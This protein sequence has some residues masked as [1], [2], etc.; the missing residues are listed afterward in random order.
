MNTEAGCT[1]CRIDALY[2]DR[3]VDREI[4]SMAYQVDENDSRQKRAQDR[5]ERL[6]K[7][8]SEE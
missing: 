8:L 2:F 4:K 5:F 1:L 7:R 3:I 6:S